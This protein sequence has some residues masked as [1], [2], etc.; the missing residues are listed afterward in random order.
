MQKFAKKKKRHKKVNTGRW[1]LAHPSEPKSKT[2]ST[3]KEHFQNTE[4]GVITGGKRQK[5]GT[6]PEVSFLTEVPLNGSTPTQSFWD[7]GISNPRSASRTRTDNKEGEPVFPSSHNAGSS[8]PSSCFDFCFLIYKMYSLIL[9]FALVYLSY[10]SFVSF[11]SHITLFS[12][13]KLHNVFYVISHVC[14]PCSFSLFHTLLPLFTFFPFFSHFSTLWL[15]PLAL[16]TV[17]YA[18]Q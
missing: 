7:T 10:M 9:C 12:L 3:W 4:D 17:S 14:N 13:Y 6:W 15:M 16:N 5:T 11:L 2:N 1:D 8:S 18:S